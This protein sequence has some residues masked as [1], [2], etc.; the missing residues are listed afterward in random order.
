M[1]QDSCFASTKKPGICRCPVWKAVGTK[2]AGAADGIEPLRDAD[3]T[4]ECDRHSLHHFTCFVL[5]KCECV[6]LLE[7]TINP[8]AK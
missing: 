1:E 3:S 8:T 7:P 6:L 2:Q 4:R 5:F